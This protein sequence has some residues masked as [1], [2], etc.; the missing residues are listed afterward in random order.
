MLNRFRKLYKGYSLLLDWRG[1]RRSL[2]GDVPT[3]HEELG[4]MS[5]VNTDYKV[6]KQIFKTKKH[7]LSDCKVFC[8]VGCGKGRVINYLL[9]NGFSGKII[10][11]ELDEY[12]AKFTKEWSRRF[13]NVTIINNNVL[14]IDCLNSI[15]VFYLYNPFNKSVLEAFVD[16]L[17]MESKHRIRIIYCNALYPEVFNRPNWTLLDNFQVTTNYIDWGNICHTVLIVEMNGIVSVLSN[18]DNSSLC[19]C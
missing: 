13:K 2:R 14:N 9:I 11:I 18:K 8:D 17:E 7:Y 4:A 3:K 6:L 16:K 5:T 1:A 15:D 12:V 19:D 10:G